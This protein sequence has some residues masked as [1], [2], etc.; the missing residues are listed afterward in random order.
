MNL[1]D[2]ISSIEDKEL[3][4]LTLDYDASNL[5]QCEINIEGLNTQIIVTPTTLSIS[6]FYKTDPATLIQTYTDTRKIIIGYTELGL[7]H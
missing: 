4:T 1:V 6:N 2:F 7:I 3:E 5:T